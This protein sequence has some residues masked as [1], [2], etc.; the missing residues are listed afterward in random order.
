LNVPNRE[1]L[2]FYL[3]SSFDYSHSTFQKKGNK[4]R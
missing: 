1:W 4:H 3:D 2:I